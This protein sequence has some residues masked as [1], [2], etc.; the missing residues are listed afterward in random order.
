MAERRT[1]MAAA[2]RNA[3][4]G[5]CTELVADLNHLS[6]AGIEPGLDRTLAL[7]H[8][9]G[10]PQLAMRGVLVG[11]TNGKGSTC[12]YITECLLAAGYSVGATPKPHLYTYRERISINGK[13]LSPDEFCAVLTEATRVAL[14]IAGD[15]GVPTEFETITAAA[16]LAISSRDID[17]AVIEV[18]LGGR[19]DSTNTLGLDVKAI[20]AIGLD[21]QE[22]LGHTIEDIAFEK[23]GIVHHGD[24]VIS[25][26]LGDGPTQVLA[27]RVSDTE[28]H[29]LRAGEGFTWTATNTGAVTIETSQRTVATRLKM[30]G[31]HQCANAAVAVSVLDQLQN[32]HGLVVTDSAMER[33]LGGIQVPGRLHVINLTHAGVNLVLDG[34]H[35]AD[36]VTAA[37]RALEERYVG[38]RVFHVIFSAMRDKDWQAM[39]DAIPPAWPVTMCRGETARAEEPVVLATYRRAHALAPTEACDEGVLGT[40]EDVCGRE[41]NVLV[42]GSLGFL[43][44]AYQWCSDNQNGADQLNLFTPG[45]TN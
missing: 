11:G 38:H 29:W 8:A 9:L 4:A 18:G 3:A 40:L 33:A 37:V 39:L 22:Y 5:R 24:A 28:A 45:N 36:G 30:I 43:A 12:A 1:L 31:Q 21:H 2:H 15:V 42:T 6:V 7:L 27:R 13:P 17:C 16:A 34:G 26:P 25:G 41:A 32:R 44:P 20:T 10:D 23:A 14:Q 19:L 35:N